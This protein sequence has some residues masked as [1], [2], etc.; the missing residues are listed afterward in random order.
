MILILILLYFIIV[1]S[2]DQLFFEIVNDLKN[3]NGTK[4][5]SPLKKLISLYRSAGPKPSDLITWNLRRFSLAYSALSLTIPQLFEGNENENVNLLFDELLEIVLTRNP[6]V[7]ATFFE[8]WAQNLLGNDDNFE[9]FDAIFG[10]ICGAIVSKIQIETKSGG[11]D[12]LKLITTE[13]PNLII[14]VLGPMCQV[15]SIA[16][17]LIKRSG[18]FKSE[19]STPDEA[20]N[21]SLIGVLLKGIAVD[22]P[23]NFDAMRSLLPNG[24]GPP[25]PQQIL[26]TAFQN[27]RDSTELI[28][29]RIQENILLPLIKGNVEFRQMVLKHVAAVAKINSNRAKLQAEIGTINSDGFIMGWWGILLKLCDPFTLAGD[30]V[31]KSKLPLIGI[32]FLI[33]N[34]KFIKY[35]LFIKYIY[36]YIYI[37]FIKYIF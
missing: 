3:N 5:K 14:S 17:F 19:F 37:S 33:Y 36:K 8:D 4:G 26:L 6:N 20:L 16:E 7:F 29:S 35:I 32:N 34:S 10:G 24:Y 12:K 28:L 13:I 23:D 27:L 9:I 30:S 1:N 22:A 11:D 15:P 2:L 18:Y 25:L 31:R 21:S